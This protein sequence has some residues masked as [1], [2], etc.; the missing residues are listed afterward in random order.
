MD[1][2]RLLWAGQDGAVPVTDEGMTSAPVIAA[3][4]FGNGPVLATI[5]VNGAP[6]SA[7]LVGAQAP[8]QAAQRLYLPAVSRLP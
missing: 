8:P 5:F 1:S 4:A 2:G 7:R 3:P 6:S